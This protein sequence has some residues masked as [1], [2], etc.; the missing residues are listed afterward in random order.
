MKVIA[1]IAQKGGVGKTTVTVTLAVAAAA[2]GHSVAVIDLDAQA[3]ASSWSDR[4]ES[5]T[6]VVISAQPARLSQVLE[7]AA[8]QGADF[9]FIDTAPRA[10]QGALAAARAADLVVTPCRPAIYDLETVQ[11]TLDLVRLA[12]RAIPVVC[13]LN[14]VPPR[15][16]R[17]HQARDVLEALGVTICPTGIGHRAAIDH[18]AALGLSAQEHEPRGKA[19][20]EAAAVYEFIAEHV[21]SFATEPRNSETRVEG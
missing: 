13:V 19:A 17:Q 1:V 20:S 3:T 14:G 5:D 11:T 8:G 12:E 16:Q 9:V 21:N 2:D 18:A 10:E 6:P 4:R 15:G 7:A